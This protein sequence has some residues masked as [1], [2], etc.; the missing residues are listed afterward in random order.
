MEHD[1]MTALEKIWNDRL[2]MREGSFTND[3]G[4]MF[5]PTS[6]S[7]FRMHPDFEEAFRL[8]TQ[9]DAFRGLD[10]VR[11]WSMVLN[12]KNVLAKC[13]GSVAEL[14]VYQGQSSALLS[15]YARKFGR[16]MYLADTFQGFMESQYEEGMGEGKQAAF[17]DVSLESAK[18]V[19]GEY[20]GN[21]WIVGMFPD[22]V[23]KEMQE[24]K[25]AFVSIDCD[26]YE[27]ILR[28][29]EFFW[30]RMV[31]GGVILIHDYSS[32]HWPGATRAVDEFCVQ[33]GVRGLLLPDFA[34][35]YVL[36]RQAA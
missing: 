36:V 19:V 20:E 34:G 6:F 1:I 16:K 25:Y 2:Y 13:E 35:S 9:H 7:E 15:F 14:G 5:Q 29:L 22:S 11:V 23:T 30:P 4:L 8:W 10:L 3:V 24:D 31:P 12:A 26:I 21:R 18:A 33:S 17:K 27:P 28:G 32:G